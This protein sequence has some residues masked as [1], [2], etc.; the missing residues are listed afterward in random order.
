VQQKPTISNYKRNC[1]Y[2]TWK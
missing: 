1:Y 2:F